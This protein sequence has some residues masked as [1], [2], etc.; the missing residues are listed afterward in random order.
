[1]IGLHRE[2]KT[3]AN[4]SYKSWRVS[5]VR[6]EFYPASNFIVTRYEIARNPLLAIQPP[7]VATL[8][9]EIQPETK[10]L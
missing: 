3:T 2:I 9:K 8:K 6:V 7:L 1:L 10:I 5:V 4:N